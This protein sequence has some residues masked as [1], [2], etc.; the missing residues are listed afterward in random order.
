MKIFRIILDKMY[1]VKFINKF[2]KP[3]LNALDEL[4]LRNEYEIKRTTSLTDAEI[5]VEELMEYE[6]VIWVGNPSITPITSSHINYNEFKEIRRFI[7][8]STKK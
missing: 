2:F 6:Y 8:S 5:T 1:S 4:G 3:I 7:E